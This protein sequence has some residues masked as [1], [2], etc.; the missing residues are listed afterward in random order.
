MRV[1]PR[2]NEELKR[3]L[4]R[5]SRPLRFEGIYSRPGH[6][7]DDPGEWVLR[8]WN[9]GRDDAAAEG[10]QRAVAGSWRGIDRLLASPM[11]T[12]E[13]MYLLARI[14]PRL[15]SGNIDHRLRQLDFR[16]QESE[17]AYPNLGLRIADVEQLEGMLV[18]G[19]NLRHEMPD[20]GHRIRKAA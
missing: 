4:D 11:A 14:G 12:V 19:S 3:D 2:E 8:R 5:G 1:V 16:A 6:A 18:I 15:G 13:E 17:A 20:V 9:G 7:T 10:L